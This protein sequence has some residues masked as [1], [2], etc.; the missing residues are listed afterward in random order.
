MAK[1]KTYVSFKESDWGI[2]ISDAAR[3]PLY[4]PPQLIG[5][6]TLEVHKGK[7]IGLQPMDRSKVSIPI[8]VKTR[9]YHDQ[10]NGYSRRYKNWDGKLSPKAI[11]Q[12]AKHG[13]INNMNFL[14]DDEISAEKKRIISEKRREKKEQKKKEKAVKIKEKLEILKRQENMKHQSSIFSFFTKQTSNKSTKS[15][16][17]TK[18]IHRKY[19]TKTGM[20][21]NTVSTVRD[22]WYHAK[23]P[24][25]RT[26]ASGRVYY[27]RRS[28]R[29]D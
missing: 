2:P 16:T 29:C 19:D 25:R 17:K 5:G 12:L 23:A 22:G 21:N 10:G 13:K 20:I 4:N 27:E 24:G 14:S 6:Y 8:N 9:R 7:V 11:T 26:S 3:N 15:K 28:N 18:K 1:Q